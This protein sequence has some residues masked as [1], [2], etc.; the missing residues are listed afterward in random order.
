[1]LCFQCISGHACC[2]L[3]SVS[4]MPRYNSTDD[5]EKKLMELWA[6]YQKAKQG[7]MSDMFDLELT[8]EPEQ[9]SPTNTDILFLHCY[10]CFYRKV[11]SGLTLYTSRR[12][13]LKVMAH[14]CIFRATKV[15]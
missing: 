5:L 10:H 15:E 1:M 4:E 9:H 8:T 13:V 3:L 14:D 7:Q 2:L 11:N 6:A 12:L